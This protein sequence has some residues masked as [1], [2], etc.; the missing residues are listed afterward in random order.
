MGESF[1]SND[2]LF[3]CF[4]YLFVAGMPFRPKFQPFR[5]RPG[6]LLSGV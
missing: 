5:H 3:L 2:E 1:N 6:P 4:V